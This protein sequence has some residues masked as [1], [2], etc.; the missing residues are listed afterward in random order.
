MN[1]LLLHPGIILIIFGLFIPRIRNRKIISI[2]PILALISLLSFQDGMQI[3]VNYHSYEL[4]FMN[5]DRLSRLF[6]LIF[7][8]ILFAISIFSINQD[9]RKEISFA[10]IYVGASISVVLS[11]DLITL[12]M[13]CLSLFAVR[14]LCLWSTVLRGMAC[15]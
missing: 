14:M 3:I 12:F 1:N 11:G 6:T 9:N 5:I 8:L 2:I 4:I 7:I 10:Y 15:L 13:V